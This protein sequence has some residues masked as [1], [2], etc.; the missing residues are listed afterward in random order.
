MPLSPYS[1]G[2]RLNSSLI[3][4]NGLARPVFYEDYVTSLIST[5]T[6][7]C[8]HEFAK[9]IYN[10]GGFSPIFGPRKCAAAMEREAKKRAPERALGPPPR[11]PQGGPRGGP[12]GARGAPRGG[13]P[14]RGGSRG[15]PGG[16]PPQGGLEALWVMAKGRRDLLAS[17]VCGSA[18]VLDAQHGLF[19]ATTLLTC[20]SISLKVYIARVP[21]SCLF[22]RTALGRDI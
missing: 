22:P 11:G 10:K 15:G 14:P 7:H 2:Q 16:D 8:C 4:K 19:R 5:Q 3:R 18:S 13:T 9:A 1:S 12:G 6:Y 21:G 17:A 20:T